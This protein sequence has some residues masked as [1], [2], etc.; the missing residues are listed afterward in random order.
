[1]PRLTL[2]LML[3]T[4]CQKNNGTSPSTNTGGNNN[5]IWW[6]PAA[7]ISFDWDLDDIRGSD[8]FYSAVVDVDAFTTSAETVAALHAAG[9]KVIAYISV[10]TL[11]DDRPDAS[12]LP[13]EV[14]GK[15]YDEWPHEKWIDIR[16]IDKLD[17]W[18]NERIAMIV[19]KGFDGVEPDNMDGY[20]NETGFAI[21]IDD[22]K[23]YADYLIEL[24]HKNGLSIGQKNIADLT[25]EYAAK[26]DWALTEDA[27]QQ[28]WQNSMTQYIQLNKPVFAVE[29]TD[30]TTQIT[31]ENTVC[32]KARAMG[33][34]TI[35]KKRGLDKWTYKCE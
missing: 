12:L 34:T 23:K 26:F 24:M 13:K 32:P 29:Y 2:L 15:T 31:F 11:E 9:K 33:F 16:Q 1:M 25:A 3:F 4:A 14:I 6:K 10:G 35:L 27:F 8:T 17:A 19:E 28:G 5:G 22:T 30:V 18:L 21:S 20:D 7:G